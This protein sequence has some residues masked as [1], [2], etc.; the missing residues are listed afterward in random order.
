MLVIVRKT[1]EG[2]VLSEEIK[3]TVLEVGKDRVR[4]G[5]DAPKD[6]KIVREELY[7]TEKQNKEAAGALP[8]NILEEL[9]KNK[10]E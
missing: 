6:V 9:M 4:I 1:G 7:S 10:K 8:K 2:V 5:I 3:I